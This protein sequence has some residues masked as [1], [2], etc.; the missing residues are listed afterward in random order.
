MREVPKLLFKSNFKRVQ[1]KGWPRHFSHCKRGKHYK[2]REKWCGHPLVVYL[3][4]PYFKKFCLDGSK[5]NLVVLEI[6]SRKLF[7]SLH[8]MYVSLRCLLLEKGP[9]ENFSLLSHF[10]TESFYCFCDKSSQNQYER[11]K[12]AAGRA[13]FQTFS[14]Y[15]GPVYRVNWP[16]RKENCFHFKGSGALI[17]LEL[18][19]PSWPFSE[20]LIH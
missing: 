14:A 13:I 9:S 20:R 3:L 4:H 1:C 19:S 6:A 12:F 18:Y 8:K 15:T 2:Q 10:A 17:E 7:V 5:L 11:I 16:V